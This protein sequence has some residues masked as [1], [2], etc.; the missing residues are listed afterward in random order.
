[1]LATVVFGCPF[2]DSHPIIHHSNIE[3]ACAV[4]LLFLIKHLYLIS[5]C[6][7]EDERANTKRHTCK[8]D[9]D[10]TNTKYDIQCHLQ[11]IIT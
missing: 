8:R 7:S 3:D 1:M 2:L 6:F 11:F 10:N 4:L 9:L 5:A